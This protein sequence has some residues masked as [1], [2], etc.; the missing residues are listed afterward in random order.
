MKKSGG[1]SGIDHHA[2]VEAAA[3]RSVKTLRIHSPASSGRRDLGICVQ[4]YALEKQADYELSAGW[5]M[6]AK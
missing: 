3:G 1:L 6:P 4:G 5:D 2:V